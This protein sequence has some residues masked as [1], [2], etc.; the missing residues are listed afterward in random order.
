[1]SM[2]T[3][4]IHARRGPEALAVT[5]SSLVSGV[6][7]GVIADAVVIAEAHNPE[8]SHIAEATGAEFVVVQAG[9]LPWVSGA[10]R[11]RREWMLCLEAG[12]IPLE[13]WISAIDRFAFIAARENYPIGRLAR[14]SHSLRQW[15]SDFRARL[16]SQPCA[17][18]VVH[19]SRLCG[20]SKVARIDA[21]VARQGLLA[22]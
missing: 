20:R 2:L 6:A 19:I 10:R 5:L 21:H 7:E 9:E 14:R 13:G 22:S 18:D 17:G 8:L 3:A 16:S 4:L 15:I 11:A 12:D 1:M